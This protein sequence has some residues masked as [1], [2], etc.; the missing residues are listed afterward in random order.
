MDG[1]KRF[2]VAVLTVIDSNGAVSVDFL[3]AIDI[4]LEGTAEMLRFNLSAW[5]RRR[6]GEPFDDENWRIVKSWLFDAV[7]AHLQPGDHL[8]LV[9]HESAAGIP[10]HVAAAEQW[11]ASYSSGWMS[12]LSDSTNPPGSRRAIAFG[13]L[14]YQIRKGMR[15]RTILG[16]A[17][18]M[19]I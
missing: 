3:P 18:E 11:A 17:G 7:G 19:P 10:W 14:L 12:L 8:V 4:D 1:S 5:T 2:I 9:D 15:S 16:A 6:K 13:R